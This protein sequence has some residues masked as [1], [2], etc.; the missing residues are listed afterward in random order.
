MNTLLGSF[1][2]HLKPITKLERYRKENEVR[3]IVYLF[4][5]TDGIFISTVMFSANILNFE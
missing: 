2:S 4:T 3:L 1:L 5:A